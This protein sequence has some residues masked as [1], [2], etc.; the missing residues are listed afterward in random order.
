MKRNGFTLIELLVVIAIIA[1]LAAILFPVFAKAREKARQTACLSNVKQLSLAV[2]MYAQDYDEKLP[3]HCPC[4][5]SGP[6]YGH[7]CAM[8]EIFPYVKSSALYSCP[9]IGHECTMAGQAYFS[10]GNAVSIPRSYGWNLGLDRANQ[11]RIQYPSECIAIADSTNF[12]QVPLNDPAGYRVD[13]TGNGY[14]APAPRDPACCGAHVTWGRVGFRHNGG[15]NCAFL[16]GHAKWM[17]MR[18]DVFGNNG[19]GRYWG[20]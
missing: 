1:I 3:R 10:G 11:A 2:Q 17:G 12:D 14:L 19:E 20:S 15:A 9:S 18:A 6:P 13:C 4:C 7:T 8:A 5:P 16:D